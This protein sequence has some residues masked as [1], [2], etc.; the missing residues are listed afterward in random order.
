MKC[1]P[2]RT[3][4]TPGPAQRQIAEQ[5]GLR[6]HHD[7][8]DARARRRRAPSSSSNRLSTPPSWRTEI[9]ISE[10]DSSVPIIQSDG[11]RD[12]RASCGGGR[13]L[14]LAQSARLD[15]SDAHAILLALGCYSASGW[16]SGRALSKAGSF[17]QA[18]ST[19]AI[20]G[21]LRHVDLE[22]A[23]V[24]HLR[25]EAEVGERHMRAERVGAGPHQRLERVEA[26]RHPVAIP[27]VGRRLVVLERTLQVVQR[28]QIV[29]RMDVAGDDLRNGAHLRALDRDRPGSSGGSRIDLV[30]IFDDRERLQQHLAG[31]ERE[32]RHALLRI[33]RAEFLAPLPAAVA[34]Q[35]HRLLVGA[36][37]SG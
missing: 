5:R 23:R 22:A 33:D 34:R 9:A 12:I 17:R 16:F 15:G 3:R 35:V 24:E 29:Q 31:G 4:C 18:A 32:R 30:E 2:L 19:A 26:L 8:Q 11:G 10:N 13:L 25:H 27:V 28:H 21:Y 7:E 37:S 20:F 14:G 1:V 6:R 36:A